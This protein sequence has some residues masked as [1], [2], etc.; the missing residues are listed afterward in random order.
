MTGDAGPLQDL[1]RAIE[2]N[3]GPLSRIQKI[4]LLT[5]GSVTALLEAIAGAEVTITTIVQE[6]VPA[7][8][9]TARNLDVRVGSG[10]NH[11]V[12][13]LKNS[14][15]GEVL[16]AAVSDTPL[17]RLEPGFRQDLM[18]ADIPIGKILKRHAIESRREIADISVRMPNEQVRRAFSISPA[19][20]LL[21][22]RYRI[23]RQG[24]PFIAIEECFPLAAFRSA[25]RVMVSA[26][27]RLHIGLIDLNGV[28]GRVDGGIGIALG[29]PRTV[30]IAEPAPLVRVNGA[31]GEILL[32]AREVAR[33]VT[34]ALGISGGVQITLRTSPPGHV[35]LGSGTA[36]SLAVA[37]AITELYGIPVPADQLAAMTGRGGTSGIGTAAFTMG[38]FLLD[39][40]H[41][42]GAA[43]EK[44]D[45]R[46]SRASRGV[47]V[48]PVTARHD[49]PEDWQILLVIPDPG[50]T[51]HGS[52][53]EDIFRAGCPVPVGDVAA[54]C[55]EVVMRML[56]GIVEHDLDLFAAAVNRIQDLGFKRIEL[57][58]QAA[59]VPALM[60]GLR[61][62][63]APCAGMSSFG[64][65]VYA[66]TDSSLSGL[67][68]AARDILGDQGGSV[69][70]TSADNSGA[71]IRNI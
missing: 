34:G 66:V 55:H 29:H 17:E 56:P 2:E 18:R 27:S 13:E 40:G 47:R 52:T 51:V 15:T 62:A 70:R 38:G 11:R 54:T 48:A 21:S 41:S 6:V 1:I 36:L 49:F 19:D 4:L 20:P 14:Q 44:Q 61:D 30:V 53:E 64:P 68:S 22:R 42:F 58:R 3:Y 57:A 10:V 28:L 12:V 5:D 45:F 43:G 65:A 39:G 37:R 71:I 25:H 63:G 31:E 7:S 32:R 9:D 16:I 59:V 60:A 24:K 35:G 67:E 69:I 26:P 50:Q 46:P 33:A 23:I 8:K